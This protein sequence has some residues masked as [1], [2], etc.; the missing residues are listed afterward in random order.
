MDRGLDRSLDEILG[1]RKQV[2]VESVAVCSFGPR[3]GPWATGWANLQGCRTAAAEEVHA[4]AVG[5]IV[6][7][8]VTGPTIP[9][10]ASERYVYTCGPPVY[11]STIAHAVVWQRVTG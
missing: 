5:V 7:I 9:E 6:A 2:R 4:V 1:D 8:V 10:M 3:S 11:H